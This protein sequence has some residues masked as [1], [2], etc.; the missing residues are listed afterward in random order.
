LAALRDAADSPATPPD[1]ELSMSE[2]LDFAVKAHGGL[3]RWKKVKSIEV[4]AS[5][6]GAI[7]Y[8]K[9][10]GDFLRTWY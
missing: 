1:K 4:A 10:K 6:T 5:I 3:D 9:G 7:W 2:P 8:V